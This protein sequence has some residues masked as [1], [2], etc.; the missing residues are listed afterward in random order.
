MSDIVTK[1]RHEAKASE[2][3]NPMDSSIAVMR[4]SANLIEDLIEVLDAA[5]KELGGIAADLIRVKEETT[6]PTP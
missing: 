3:L 2:E 5:G 6:W 4:T 1:L